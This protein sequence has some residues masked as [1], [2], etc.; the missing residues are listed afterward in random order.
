MELPVSPVFIRAA[1]RN[2]VS[3]CDVVR[4]DFRVTGH[5]VENANHG[6]AFREESTDCVSWVS[7]ERTLESGVNIESAGIVPK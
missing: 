3:N 2:A 5:R 7:P 4:C 1:D 6:S